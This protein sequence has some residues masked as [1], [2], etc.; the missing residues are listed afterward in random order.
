M[1]AKQHAPSFSTSDAITV[2]N[3]VHHQPGE[4]PKQ[5]ALRLFKAAESDFTESFARSSGPGGQ[6]A[7]KVSSSVTVTHVPTG[8]SVRIEDSRSQAKNREI[9]WER[10]IERIRELRAAA[11]RAERS[12]IEKERRRSRP[13]P[14]GVKE[15][16]LDT[17]RKRSEI[18]RLRQSP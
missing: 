4:S 2:P 6:H 3:K 5:R 10:I 18:K 11:R 1:A 17:K 14:R 9:A 13:R 12:A 7:N 15:R 8:I 16:I